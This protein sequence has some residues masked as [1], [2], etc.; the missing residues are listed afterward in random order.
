MTDV[1]KSAIRNFPLMQRHIE[2]GVMKF[3]ISNAFLLALALIVFADVLVVSR[4]GKPDIAI[5]SGSIIVFVLRGLNLREQSTGIVVVG[6]LFALWV[7]ADNGG[8]LE[9]SW[10]LWTLVGFV[11]ALLYALWERLFR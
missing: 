6:I 8:L 4:S 1:W 5:S 11:L 9:S 2:N 10:S 7:L 3:R